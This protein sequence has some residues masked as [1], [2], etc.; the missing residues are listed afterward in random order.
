MAIILMIDC[1]WKEFEE[2]TSPCGHHRKHGE[3]LIR[4]K[5]IEP[6]ILKIQK[7]ISFNP[8]EANR[9]GKFLCDLADKHNVTMIGEATPTMVGPS[10]T[11]DN[12]FFIGMNLERL[13]RWYNHYGFNSVEENGKHIITRSP[14]N[15]G[16]N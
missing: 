8:F 5:K 14:K 12:T 9:T 10:V 13:L 4:C 3:V 15:E 6:D 16:E 11:K 7:F 2:K 1:F